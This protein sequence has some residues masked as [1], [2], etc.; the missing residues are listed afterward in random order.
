MHVTFF[1]KTDFFERNIGIFLTT[2]VIKMKSNLQM[3]LPSKF[4]FEKK[5]KIVKNIPQS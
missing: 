4:I 1:F 2:F 3:F 5:K